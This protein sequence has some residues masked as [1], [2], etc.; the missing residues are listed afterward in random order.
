MSFTSEIKKEIVSR[1]RNKL[2]GDEA[3]A[4]LSAFVSTSG[5]VGVADGAPSFF[6]VSESETVAE[7]FTEIFIETF[8]VELR[9]TSARLDKMSGR[10]KLLLQCPQISCGEVLKELGLLTETGETASGVERFMQT[11]ETRSAYIKGAFLGGGSCILPSENTKSGYHLEFVFS[12][13]TAAEEFCEL[14]D[15]SSMIAKLVERKETFVAYIKSKEMIS[16]FLATI[17]A[18]NALKKFISVQDK[19]EEANRQNRAA[20]C[21]SGNADK[22]A[23]AAVKQVVAIQKLVADASFK[24]LDEDLK[25]L[26]LLRL[27][28]TTKSLKELATALGVSKSCLSHRMRRLIELSERM[29]K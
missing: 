16:D 9:V 3:K 17:G 19:R 13:Q 18:D 28:E 4:A 10:D 14:L 24:D 27:K 12:D 5:F 7:F 2:K 25:A 11:E 22:T 21:I 23:L 15:A 20:N 8:G 29:G 26:A 1:R 6:I